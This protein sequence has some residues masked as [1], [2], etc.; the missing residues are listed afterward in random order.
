M[1]KSQSGFCLWHGLRGHW[2]LTLS[3]Q[4]GFLA[5]SS[6]DDSTSFRPSLLIPSPA[7]Q[8]VR[9]LSSA[10][11]T[12]GRSCPRFLIGTDYV[13]G[14]VQCKVGPLVQMSRISRWRQQILK[15][16]VGASKCKVLCPLDWSHAQKSSLD[17]HLDQRPFPLF[18]CAHT[19]WA[20]P[21]SHISSSV[22]AKAS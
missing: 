8:L 5:G 14:G 12:L 10:T 16:I 19:H 15:P 22:A 21:P 7:S 17:S 1:T 2:C 13:I 9:P 20:F 11:S 18:W 3:L 4:L 6:K